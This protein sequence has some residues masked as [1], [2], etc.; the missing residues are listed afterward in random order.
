MQIASGRLFFCCSQMELVSILNF[1]KNKIATLVKN[2]DSVQKIF[3]NTLYLY[4]R[5]CRKKANKKPQE[6]EVLSEKKS[7]RFCS[8]NLKNNASAGLSRGQSRKR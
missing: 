3:F 7:E 2:P 4:E 1:D 8:K 6:I 5:Q